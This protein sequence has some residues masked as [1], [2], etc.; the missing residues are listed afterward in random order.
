[1]STSRDSSGAKAHPTETIAEA[2]E[3][4]RIAIIPPDASVPQV[5]DC[6]A[7]FYAGVQWLYWLLLSRLSATSTKEQFAALMAQTGQELKDFE[8]KFADRMAQD[9]N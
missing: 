6:E 8:Q 9:M 4:Y 2:F 5:Q 1:M 3:S 7:T